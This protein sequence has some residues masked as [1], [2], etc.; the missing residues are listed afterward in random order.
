MAGHYRIQ[1]PETNCRY[2]SLSTTPTINQQPIEG[3]VISDL[4]SFNVT[5]GFEFIH[6]LIIPF[7]SKLSDESGCFIQSESFTS[8]G[9][10]HYPHEAV[11]CFSEKQNITYIMAVQVLQK[12]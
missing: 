2:I 6:P 4:N 8:S 1:L 5:N 10:I 11:Q 7:D 9:R 12:K 3:I